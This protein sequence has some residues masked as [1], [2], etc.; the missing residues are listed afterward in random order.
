M[1]GKRTREEVIYEKYEERDLEG[2]LEKMTRG[3]NSFKRM[4][5]NKQE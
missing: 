3:I 4:F 2:T 1:N 5:L